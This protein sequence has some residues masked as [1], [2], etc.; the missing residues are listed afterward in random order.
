MRRRY[1]T[2]EVRVWRARVQELVAAAFREEATDR[3]LSLV[4]FARVDL[5]E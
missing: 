2:S 4:A 5:T 1:A 3:C